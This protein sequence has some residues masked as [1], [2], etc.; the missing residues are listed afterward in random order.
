MGECRDGRRDGRRR[1]RGSMT[2]R[3]SMKM[4]GESD[5]R[6]T[7]GGYRCPASSV[8]SVVDVERLERGS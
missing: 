3:A 8:R 5:V 7:S 6:K 4:C 2:R 1:G